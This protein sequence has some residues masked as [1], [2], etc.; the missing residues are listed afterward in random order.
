MLLALAAAAYGHE[1]HVKSVVLPQGRVQIEA[2]FSAEE[3]LAG[4][5]VRVR[6]ANGEVLH[7]GKLDARGVYRF[8]AERAEELRIDVQ[9][10]LGHRAECYVNREDLL[11]SFL[12]RLTRQALAALA[13]PEPWPALVVAGLPTPT[14]EA[15]ADVADDASPRIDR[16][17]PFP[18]R[19]VFTGIGFLLA[20]AAFVLS[21]QNAKKLRGMQANSQ[22]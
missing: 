1:A 13:S 2:W 16:H 22:R 7:T 19:D 17:Q 11:E 10:R 8:T 18:W 4:A 15:D 6:L 5:A 9:D 14:S 3:P 12:P 21:V 20:L